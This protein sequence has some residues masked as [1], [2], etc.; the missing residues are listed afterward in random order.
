[1]FYLMMCVKNLF[2]YKNNYFSFHVF[3]A[4]YDISNIFRGGGGV[5]NKLKKNNSFSFHVYFAFYFISNIFY[6]FFGNIEKF[7]FAYWLNGKWVLQ[8]VDSNF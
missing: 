2:S 8:I 1:M 4:F 7:P 5:K 6:I 3:F